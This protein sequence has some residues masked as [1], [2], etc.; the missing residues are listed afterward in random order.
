M[1]NNEAWIVALN[2]EVLLSSKKI[3]FGVVR[4]LTENVKFKESLS[5][6][7][8]EIQ[9]LGKERTATAEEIN[10]EIEAFNQEAFTGQFSLIK[11][12]LIESHEDEEIPLYR[13][14]KIIEKASTRSILSFLDT[15]G[16]IK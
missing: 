2:C 13:D 10:A 11:S 6:K 16:L 5:N 8:A 15:K 14:G 4:A 7:V 9:N 1:T 12:E 3:V